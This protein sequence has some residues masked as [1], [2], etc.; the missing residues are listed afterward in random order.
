MVRL[1]PRQHRPHRHL[2]RVSGHPVTFRPHKD[3]K[4]V[5]T[6]T[7]KEDESKH[8]GIVSF[9]EGRVLLSVVGGDPVVMGVPKHGAW[10]T[11]SHLYTL[12][13]NRD[14]ITRRAEEAEEEAS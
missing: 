2:R 11:A 4:G 3:G 1:R 9:A 12:I 5:I 6:L 14:E 8:T 7:K 10:H 13:V